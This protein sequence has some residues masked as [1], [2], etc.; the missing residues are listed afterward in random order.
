MKI[1]YYTNTKY[2]WNVQGTTKSI[3]EEVQRRGHEVKIV[4]RNLIGNILK[5][6][7]ITRPDCVWLASSD[8]RIEQFKGKMSVPVI[9][10]GFSDPYIFSPERFK[11]YDIYV[12][13]HEGTLKRYGHILPI[14]YNPTACDI[15]F[16]KNL[17]TEKEIDVS[18]IG[19]YN[20]PRFADK[21]MRPKTVNKLRSD[22]IIVHT[23][24][25]GW[26]P[27][28]LPFNHKAVNGQGFLNVINRSKI[29]IDL[30]DPGSPLAHRMLE[31]GACGTPC[32]TRD[33][34]EIYNLFDKDEI[35][36]YT[37]YEDLKSKIKYYL[38]NE[39]ELSKFAKKLE[40]KCR[41]NHNITNRIDSLMEFLAS[42][43]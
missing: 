36:T 29:G 32:I 8:I 9:G 16:H 14:H 41:E 24:G 28:G 20:H 34:P 17:K 6:I 13:N 23:Y 27:H 37:D 25:D 39:N 10:F 42:K 21:Q 4:S 3:A 33:R 26:A 40:K 18:C 35:L 43:L 7:Q 5:E 30:Q 12:T 11:S 2:A 15:K 31:Y 1:L 38:S 19:T 22:G